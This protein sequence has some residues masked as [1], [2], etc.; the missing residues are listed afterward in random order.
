V[1]YCE[2]QNRVLVKW[3]S[4]EEAAP[5]LGV[6]VKALRK[7]LQRGAR[8]SRRGV[9]ALL[10]DA[11]GVK[12]ASHWRVTDGEPCVKRRQAY[13]IREAAAVLGMSTAA[14]RRALERSVASAEARLGVRAEKT[15]AGRWRITFGDRWTR[16][17][18]EIAQLRQARL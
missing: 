2:R 13:R 6:D 1:N 9:E 4:P 11:I 3:L 18:E 14:L 10:P 15:R 17:P 5:R 16:R 7:R 12:F 8:A